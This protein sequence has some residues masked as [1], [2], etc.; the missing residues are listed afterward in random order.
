MTLTVDDDATPVPRRTMRWRA[1]G[2]AALIATGAVASI[3]ALSVVVVLHGTGLRGPGLTIDSTTYLLAADVYRDE[4]SRVAATL[5]GVFPPGYSA[6][7][8]AARSAAGGPLDAA[9]VVNVAALTSTI[10]LVAW[11]VWSARRWTGQAGTAGSRAA[12]AVIAAALV[13]GSAAML[14]WSGAVMAEA[15]S[16]A[17]VVASAVVAERALRSRSIALCAAAGMLGGAA[18]LVRHVAL[19]TLLGLVL[20]VALLDRSGRRARIGTAA[21]VAGAGAA[22]VLAGTP[23]LRGSFD[24][25]RTVA[26]HPPGPDDLLEALDTAGG[27][28]LPSG[29]GTAATRAVAAGV[30]VLGTLLLA[31]A[32]VNVGAHD[33]APPPVTTLAL[34]LLV[35]HLA[36]VVGSMTLLDDLTPLDDRI[37]LPVV[38]L[39]ALAAGAAAGA[40]R[41][42]SVRI[43]GLSVAAL[44]LAS[45][46]G[47]VAAWVDEAR[48]DGI[49]YAHAMFDHSE[50]L[51]VV[52]QLPVDTPLWSNDV[53]L[54]YLRGHRPARLLPSRDDGYARRTAD[55]YEEELGALQDDV[56]GGAVVVVLDYFSF[57]S[58]P[59]AAELEELL[60]PVEVVR[61]TDGQLIRAAE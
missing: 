24:S 55:A 4:P 54:L 34:V 19:G 43:V 60:R 30:L 1:H 51:K 9:R 26:W 31:R 61:L 39:A 7:I 33:D 38:P 44:V 41:S 56:A 11:G 29:L 8:V 42:R 28:M 18:A 2:T 5:N 12:A 47:R 36:S 58:L 21:V 13:G 57:P 53:S 20:A 52:G 14:R 16:I 6:A 22:T 23:L 17:F 25:T 15:L 59:S 40:A 3:A 48:T 50:T 10:V 27:Y 45:Q 46:V 35:A 37:L 32:A 49:G